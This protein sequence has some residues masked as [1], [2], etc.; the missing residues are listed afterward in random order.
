LTLDA[1]VGR[2]RAFSG[3]LDTN[4]VELSLGMAL[5]DRPV[6]PDSAGLPVP[7]HDSEWAL[8]VQDYLGAQRKDGTTRSLSTLGLK[9]RRA[10][11]EHLYLSGQA[12]SAVTGGAGAYSAGLVG[13]G[14]ETR[15]TADQAW[16][17]GAEALV[18]AGGGGGVSSRGGAIAQPMVWAGRDLGRFSRIR[19]GAGVV[20][21]LRGELSSA[22]VELAWG[23][24]FGVP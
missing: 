11:G 1:E 4:H 12:H 9:F 10:L 16:R 6:R 15:L 8:S 22:V 13:M 21:S 23:V 7:V 3:G 2:T 14:L 17:V 18:G 5:G 24:E 19:L 20:K